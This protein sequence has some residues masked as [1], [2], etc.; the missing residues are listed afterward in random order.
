MSAGNEQS[1]RVPGGLQPQESLETQLAPDHSPAEAEAL[2]S[3]ITTPIGRGW[4]TTPP[5][6][7]WTQQGG[8]QVPATTTTHPAAVPPPEGCEQ[9]TTILV[10]TSI[11]TASP[12]RQLG[13]LQQQ[14]PGGPVPR[15][16]RAA[17][18]LHPITRTR[19]GRSESGDGP[20]T[21]TRSRPRHRPPE[22]SSETNTTT[23]SPPLKD[24]GVPAKGYFLPI[25][26]SAAPPPATTSHLCRRYPKP[27]VYSV[28]GRGT[29]R[30]VHRPGLP[31]GVS[32]S[33]EA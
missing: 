3:G 12:A 30:R 20:S 2:P 22:P 23:P 17:F 9:Q 18:P 8:G 28:P 25:R 15:E 14:A 4:Q 29:S 13:R 33:L 7:R 5:V 31:G 11:G 16:D 27:G 21:Q 10:R 24:L 19:R 32:L 6:P 26:V 1:A